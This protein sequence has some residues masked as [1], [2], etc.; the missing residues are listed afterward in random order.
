MRKPTQHSRRRTRRLLLLGIGIGAGF[1]VALFTGS[2][3]HADEKPRPVADTVH[4]VLNLPGRLLGTPPAKTDRPRPVRDLVGGTRDLTA[5]VLDGTT[6]T[7]TQVTDGLDEVTKPAPVVGRTVDEV[8]DLTDNVMRGG[9]PRTPT[10]GTPT[11]TVTDDEP[12]AQDDTPST[13]PA[14]TAE[15]Q[16]ATGTKTAPEPTPSGAPTPGDTDP[17]AP[18]LTVTAAQH[19]APRTAQ[20][21]QETATQHRPNRQAAAAVP[22]TP[23]WPRSVDINPGD[24]TYDQCRCGTHTFEYATPGAGAGNT[25]WRSPP[26]TGYTEHRDGRT[27]P[28]SPPS[29]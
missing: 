27:Q 18:S 6:K 10:V 11:P 2:P 14:D 5:Q 29:G 8:T 12:A 22:A 28:P 1:G 3:A 21:D 24:D 25:P 26:A 7:V 19:P 15:A 23:V 9:A 17:G 13:E 16:P 20:N 4:G